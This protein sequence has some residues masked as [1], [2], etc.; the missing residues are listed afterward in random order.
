ME[1]RVVRK[2]YNSGV[3]ESRNAAC[4]C[5]SGRKYK[6]CCL[7]KRIIRSSDEFPVV[8]CAV[9]DDWEKHGLANILVARRLKSGSLI[10]GGYL[11]DTACL[12]LKNTFCHADVLPGKFDNEMFPSHYPERK[13][14]SIGIDLVKEIVLGAIDYAAKLGF[15]PAPGFEIS[16]YVL[17][18]GERVRGGNVRFGG[19]NGKP[20]FVAGPNDDGPAIVRKLM[21]RLGKDGF[22]FMMPAPR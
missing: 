21:Q 10:V 18:S 13:P 7:K 16:R 15:D 11:A 22:D 3:E 6:K 5:G 19:M 20:F 17:G 8:G 14:L 1:S 4:S 12:G 2:R 9:N